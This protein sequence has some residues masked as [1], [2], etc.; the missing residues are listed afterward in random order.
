MALPANIRVN[1]AVPF[2]AMVQGSGPITLGKT[3]GVWT[4]GASGRLVNT[5]NP[6]IIA[7][8]YVL[9]WDD[10]AQA[11]LK[12]SLS[13]L[14]TQAAQARTQRSVT[15]SPIVIAGTDQI[16]NVN[17]SSGSATCTLPQ[18]STRAGVPLTFKD[19]GGNFAAHSVAVTAFAGD[20]IDG[21]G[22]ITLNINRQG[23]TLVPFNDSTNVGWAIQ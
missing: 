3:N 6:G 2:P 14:I 20:T 22:E 9:V 7:T 16:L 19:V 17:I 18:A 8:D 12:I 4:V 5:A 23:I 11:W 10:V 1:V 15:A 21:A 13:N